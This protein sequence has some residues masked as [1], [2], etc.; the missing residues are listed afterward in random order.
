MTNT[1]PEVL[2]KWRKDFKKSYSVPE[3]L[4]LK[5]GKWFHKQEKWAAVAEKLNELFDVFCVSRQTAVIELPNEITFGNT[6]SL[7]NTAFANGFNSAL[8]QAKYLIESQGYRVEI[9]I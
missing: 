8:E 6:Y 9:K 2:E 4:V 7:E 1:P 3:H 5:R